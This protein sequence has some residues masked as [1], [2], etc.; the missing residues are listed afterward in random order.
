MVSC[1]F[2]TRKI[3]VTV[4]NKVLSPTGSIIK[5][6]DISINSVKIRIKTGVIPIETESKYIGGIDLNSLNQEPNAVSMCA[7]YGFVITVTIQD[8]FGLKDFGSGAGREHIIYGSRAGSII[9]NDLN[10]NAVSELICPSGS[11]IVDT[12]AL[13]NLYNLTQI[14]TNL[15]IGFSSNLTT[16]DINNNNI[17]VNFPVSV[18]VNGKLATIVQSNT[19]LNL[20]FLIPKLGFNYNQ[21][22]IISFGTDLPCNISLPQSITIPKI[23]IPEI[24]EFICSD[25][26]I[27]PDQNEIYSS[28]SDLTSFPSSIYVK[29][30]SQ[31]NKSVPIKLSI[32]GTPVGTTYTGSSINLINLLQ[33]GLGLNFTALKTTNS[34]TVK[35]EL[36][37]SN[38]QWAN[39]KVNPIEFTIPSIQPKFPD[40]GKLPISCSDFITKVEQTPSV[41]DIIPAPNMPFFVYIR[42]VKE[43]CS[44]DPTNPALTKPFNG[45]GM[46]QLGNQSAVFNVVNG[47]ADFDLMK[48]I[49]GLPT[50][51][52]SQLDT[53]TPT[54]VYIPPAP[55][56]PS[57]PTSG[58]WANSSEIIQ[59]LP[60]GYTIMDFPSF[61]GVGSVKVF[62][63]DGSYFYANKWSIIASNIKW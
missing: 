52:L 12:S 50:D 42:G 33:Y 44:A 62:R 8:T 63:P 6:P 38:S 15:N 35:V 29:V 18:Y 36:D 31:S 53:Y 61:G 60:P 58:T 28:I 45:Q 11:L 1:G 37:T 16:K 2:G 47:V 34:Y 4:T 59:Y 21:D 39:C 51:G 22:N 17:V 55:S 56:K 49:G 48:L 40:L 27:K 20:V 54:E 41:P 7:I 3:K 30:T 26:L 9:Y 43:V 32:N 46:I 57:I 5:I 24:P 14:P 23:F 13:P 19:S 25:V 10:I